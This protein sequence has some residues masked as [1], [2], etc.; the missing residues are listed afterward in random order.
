MISMIAHQWRQPIT[1]IG[2]GAQNLQ[3][4]IELDDIDP[5]RFD[6][7]LTKI[8][9]QTEFLS[10]TIDDFRD[11]LKPNKKSHTYKVSAIVEGTLSVI[12][13]SI[14]NNNIR[15]E[16][17]FLDDVEIT[18]YYNEVIQVLLN[19]INNAKDI[20]NTKNINNGIITIK[21]SKDEQN[22]NIEICDNAGGIQEDILPRMFEPYFTTK[23]S[24]GGTGLGLYMSQMIIEKHLKGTITAI[25]INGGAC[26]KVALPLFKKLN[27]Q[28]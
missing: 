27:Y 28:N 22:A 14:E 10:K 18:T 9:E 16:K 13:K 20:I 2:M 19:I 7:K 15:L 6:K 24:K 23:E 11:F 17:S 21:L 5:K 25:N 3:L 8:V 12:R 1:A 26:F 4:D